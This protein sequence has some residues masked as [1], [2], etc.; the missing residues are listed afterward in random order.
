M[1]ENDLNLFREKWR[2]EITTKQQSKAENCTNIHVN[3]HGLKTDNV[4]DDDNRDS[5]G[6]NFNNTENCHMLS[7]KPKL[8]PNQPT[9]LLTL[10][11]PSYHS[12]VD[13][14]N[15]TNASN[16]SNA[17][18]P[19]QDSNEDLLSLLIRDIDETTSIPFFDVS[20]PKEVCVKIF[21]HLD[22]TDLCRCSCISKA[23]AS[24]ANDELLWHNIYKRMGFRDQGRNVRGQMDWK[25]IVRDG[26]LRQRLV[27]QNWKERICQIETFEYEKG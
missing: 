13:S 22:V 16:Q 11:I 21:G 9:A 19:N 24:I 27:T 25:S 8:E 10:E 2:N 14:G 5:Q 12:L 17:S 3:K 1:A 4:P 20:L 7:K 26:I 23:W 18:L 15:Y 6:R